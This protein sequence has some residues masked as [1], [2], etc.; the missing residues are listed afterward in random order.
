LRAKLVMPAV[1]P[2]LRVTLQADD[3]LVSP[4]APRPLVPPLRVHARVAE[5]LPECCEGDVAAE[6]LRLALPRMVEAR[7]DRPRRVV[8]IDARVS[9]YAGATC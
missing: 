3:T 4:L 2:Q 7:P 1:K 5:N 6:E 8:D 9:L